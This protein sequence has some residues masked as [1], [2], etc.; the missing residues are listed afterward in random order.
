MTTL[1]ALTPF[2]CR[3]RPSCIES[4]PLPTI[5]ASGFGT[6]VPSASAFGRNLRQMAGPT[7]FLRIEVAETEI[8]VSA[9]M[10]FRDCCVGWPYST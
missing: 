4:K 1:A 2:F 3:S 5:K 7:S 9:M 6:M 8:F 10:Q